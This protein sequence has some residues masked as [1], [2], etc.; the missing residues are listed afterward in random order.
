[1]VLQQAPDHPQALFHLGQHRLYCKDP[2]GARR[3]LERAALADPR[4]PAVPLNIA[5]SYRAVGDGPNEMAALT[6]SLTIDPYFYPALLAKGMLLERS[7]SLRKAA[8]IYKDVLTIS[9]PEDQLTGEMLQAMRHAR[10]VAE[11]NAREL[12]EFLEKRLAFIEAKHE[13]DDL[14]RFAECRG[15]AVGT[16]KIFTQK[17]SLLYFPHLPA[18]PFYD[19]AGFPW[20]KDLEAATA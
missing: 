5:F 10:E 7:G 2:M 9:P 8:K 17:P 15:I 20:L 6:R 4:N 12:D 11:Q 19:R 16:K 14:Q 3:L 18:I 13:G 1:Q